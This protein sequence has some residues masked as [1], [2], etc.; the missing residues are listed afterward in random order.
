LLCERAHTSHSILQTADLLIE[1]AEWR[2]TTVDNAL[3]TFDAG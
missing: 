3:K 2:L 1:T